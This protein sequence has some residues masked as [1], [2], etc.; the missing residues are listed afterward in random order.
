[1]PAISIAKCAE[2]VRNAALDLTGLPAQI[3]IAL[4]SRRECFLELFFEPLQRVGNDVRMQDSR[5]EAGQKLP[6]EILP[7]RLLDTWAQRLGFSLP[8]VFI[9]RSQRSL[10]VPKPANQNGGRPSLHARGQ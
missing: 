7:A 9:T 2:L 3:R 6:L 8:A 1:L 5:L 4:T 10:S